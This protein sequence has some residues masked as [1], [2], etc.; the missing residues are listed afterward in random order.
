MA[1][2]LVV[3]DNPTFREAIADV[4]VYGGH[5]VVTEARVATALIRLHLQ[6]PDLIILDMWMDQPNSGLRLA[7]TLRDNPAT[8]G[9]P[10][11]VCSAHTDAIKSFKGELDQLGCTFVP[12]P[13]DMD[14]LLAVVEDAIRPKEA[15]SHSE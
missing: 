11:I 5:T 6:R 3:D 13:F 7:R 2:I 9:I 14:H 8:R 1:Q 10:A 15:P 12:K 4:L